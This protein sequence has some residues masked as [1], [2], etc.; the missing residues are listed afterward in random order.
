MIRWLVSRLVADLR[1]GDRGV[2]YANLLR[3]ALESGYSIMN[4]REFD[5]RVKDA[6]I[7][8][9][10][11]ILAIRHDV[12][13]TNAAGNDLFF[14]LETAAGVS[15]TFYFRLSTLDAHRRLVRRLLRTGH[16]VGYHFEEGA[17]VAKRHH[18]GSRG[19]V[20]ERRQ[21]VEELFMVN[22]SRFRRSWNPDL[23]SVASHGDWVNTRLG[24]TNNELIG[25]DTLSAAGLSFEAYDAH[26]MDAAEVYV[27]DVARPPA[28][29]ADGLGLGQA[30]EQRLSPIY[31]LVHER[32]WH[33]NPIANI[34]QDMVRLVDTARYELPFR[35]QKA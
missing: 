7:A 2:E 10:E 6:S 17:A 23:V 13:I 9:D 28:L 20:F 15:S 22:S 35:T 19:A 3:L 14:A 31:V 21:E 24:F 5:A 26:L 8:A 29:W 4:V 18:L 32:N 11:A 1:P 33:T 27:S 16:E 12:D 25:A 34:R 30:L